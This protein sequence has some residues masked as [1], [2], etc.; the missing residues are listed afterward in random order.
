MGFQ[1]VKDILSQGLATWEGQN[2]QA[3]LSGHGA[4]FKWTTKAD[5]LAAMG[6]GK[7]LIQPELIGKDGAKTNLI[8]DL[9]TGIDG[10]ALRMPK[11]GPF[12]PN[13]QIQEIVDWI[14]QGCPD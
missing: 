8:V 7:R 5:L 1:R 4:T 9:R 12:I 10:P 14:N 13:P 3:D 11:G 2:G 6:H